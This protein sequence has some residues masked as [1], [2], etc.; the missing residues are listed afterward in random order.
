MEDRAPIEPRVR[1]APAAP[2]VSAQETPQPDQTDAAITV[3]TSATDDLSVP[4]TTEVDTDWWLVATLLVGALAASL[5]VVPYLLELL[6]AAGDRVVVWEFTLQS[7]A[8]RMTMVAASIVVGLT[9]GPKVGLGL[10]LL[11][12]V[13][14]ALGE[15]RERAWGTF[16]S[17]TLA[18]CAIGAFLLL[19]QPLCE[20]LMPPL[21]DAALKAEEATRT[22]SM[23]KPALAS[24]SAGVIEELLFRFGAMT[25]VLTWI[26][27][28]LRSTTP[29][30]SAVWLANLTAAFAFATLHIGNALALQIPITLGLL[31]NIYLVNGVAG[32]VLGW[33]YWRRGLE[34]AILAHAMAN[35]ADKVLSPLVSGMTQ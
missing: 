20:A 10:R 21:P 13:D 30:S 18:G 25:L 32:I 16:K 26:M 27:R 23:W 7:T 9:K 29:T 1:V 3:G 22:M 28:A 17:A 2:T 33:L 31:T 12:K 15:W 34:A 35:L 4:A 19:V 8:E 14:P 11:G 24:M 6:E 5:S